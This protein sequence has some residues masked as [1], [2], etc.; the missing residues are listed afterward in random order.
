MAGS[1]A[2][3]AVHGS[4]DEIY[5]YG[6]AAAV[7]GSAAA[8]DAVFHAAAFPCP[9]RPGSTLPPWRERKRQRQRETERERHRERPRGYHPPTPPPPNPIRPPHQPDSGPNLIHCY[10]FQPESLPNILEKRSGHLPGRVGRT[11]PSTR[12]GS[13]TQLRTKEISRLITK[14]TS[15]LMATTPARVRVCVLPPR[16]NT[17]MEIKAGL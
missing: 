2:G 17:C 8:A 11:L 1:G 12:R 15:R 5:V 7:Y 14:E 16:K 6:S 4:A 10:G 3:G 13:S 9:A